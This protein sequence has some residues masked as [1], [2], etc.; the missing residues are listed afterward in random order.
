[1]RPRSNVAPARIPPNT[2][3]PAASFFVVFISELLQNAQIVFEKRANVR[4]IELDHRGAIE[5]EAE[6]ESAPL[7]RIDTHV[8]QH[9]RMNHAAA[10]DLHPAGV[11]AGA[12]ALPAAEGAGHVHFG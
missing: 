2:V 9:L 8:S 4:D 6:R 3:A 10:E 11:G 1:I 5:A 7:I 12:A